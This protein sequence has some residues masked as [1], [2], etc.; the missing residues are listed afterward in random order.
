MV[1]EGDGNMDIKGGDLRLAPFGGIGSYS[2]GR[3][4]GSLLC[5]G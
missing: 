1:A 5:Y 2:R 4:Q 3:I